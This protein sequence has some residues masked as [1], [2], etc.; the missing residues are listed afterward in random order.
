M[1]FFSSI[2]L[3]G[4]AEAYIRMSLVYHMEI[5]KALGMPDDAGLSE[6]NLKIILEKIN[7]K[8]PATNE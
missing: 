8:L 7:G 2:I 4:N 3:N 5:N 1:F 6:A